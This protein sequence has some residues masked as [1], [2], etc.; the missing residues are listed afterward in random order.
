MQCAVD[1]GQLKDL[2]DFLLTQTEIIT[3]KKGTNNEATMDQQ[4]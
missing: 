1:A 4:Q 3:R 2:Q